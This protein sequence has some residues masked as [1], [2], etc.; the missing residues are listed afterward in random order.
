[1]ATLVNSGEESPGCN[2]RVAD[3]IGRGKPQGQYHRNHTAHFPPKAGKAKLK[4]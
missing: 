3:N 2:K 4:P 1:M